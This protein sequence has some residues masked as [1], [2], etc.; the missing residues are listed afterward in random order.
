MAEI[1]FNV[2]PRVKGETCG[3][4]GGEPAIEGGR[5]TLHPWEKLKFNL[6]LFIKENKNRIKSIIKL[7]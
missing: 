3:R 5:N 4:E 1:L 2:I 6:D 7:E